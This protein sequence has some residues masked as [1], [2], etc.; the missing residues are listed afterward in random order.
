MVT[1]CLV[2]GDCG[3]NDPAK[4]SPGLTGVVAVGIIPASSITVVVDV[5]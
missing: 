2:P 4:T 5:L 3:L 1:V